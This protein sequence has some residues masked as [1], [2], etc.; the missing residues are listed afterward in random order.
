[1]KSVTTGQGISGNFSDYLETLM[2]DLR[3]ESNDDR[4][5]LHIQ[6]FQTPLYSLRVYAPDRH[7]ELHTV[8][9]TSGTGDEI[10]DILAKEAELWQARVRAAVATLTDD[11]AASTI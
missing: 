7:T 1:M 6:V 10:R 3:T 8:K 9:M 5:R 4:W 11:R 2:S